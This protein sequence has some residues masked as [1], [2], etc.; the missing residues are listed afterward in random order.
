MKL[1]KAKA[2]ETTAIWRG[3]VRG[4]SH[5]NGPKTKRKSAQLGG[6]GGLRDASKWTAGG[7]SSTRKVSEQWTCVRRSKTNL[8]KRNS[9][10]DDDMLVRTRRRV[11]RLI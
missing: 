6:G 1:L 9:N 10:S 4:V 8:Q 5:G 7:I 2:N 3:N 11:F